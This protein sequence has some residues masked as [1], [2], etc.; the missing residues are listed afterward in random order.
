MNEINTLIRGMMLRYPTLYPNRFEAFAELMTNSCYEWHGG[1]LVAVFPMEEAT[2]VTMLEGFAQE[3]ADF[4]D[5]AANEKCECLYAFNRR[6]VVEAE[7]RLLEAQHVAG[8]IDVY[9]SDYT[10][11]DYK[12]AWAWLHNTDRHGVSEYWSINNKPDD[13]TDDWR[14]AVYEWLMFL[15]P[16][17]N[18]LMG[19]NRP[20]GFEAVPRYAPT[21]NWLKAKCEEYE[22][23]RNPEHEARMLELARE[24]AS[25]L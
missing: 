2:P 19:V 18:G 3:L 9:A 1:K 17:A 7:R 6:L 13:I 12:E 4:R 25:K 20:N 21:F 24:I 8:N 10:C 16:P 22:P 15:M 5:K 23:P 11:C 14:T